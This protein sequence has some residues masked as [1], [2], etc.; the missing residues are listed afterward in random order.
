LVGKKW[1]YTYAALHEDPKY[2]DS[3]FNSVCRYDR[4]TKTA[5]IRKFGMDNSIAEPI[6]VEDETGGYMITIVYRSDIDKSMVHLLDAT[7]LQDICVVEL[8]EVIPPGF[9]GRWDYDRV[10]R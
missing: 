2:P 3:F 6:L 5:E 8:P 4:E 1:R 9:H 7:S 10:I